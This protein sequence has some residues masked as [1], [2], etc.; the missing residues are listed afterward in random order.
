VLRVVRALLGTQ[1]LVAH[2][3]LLVSLKVP[4]EV[5]RVQLA[6]YIP[7]QTPQAQQY[8]QAALATLLRDWAQRVVLGAQRI[9]TRQARAL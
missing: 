8:A 6:Q 4:W 2:L 5:Q 3:A 9:S 1:E 7:S